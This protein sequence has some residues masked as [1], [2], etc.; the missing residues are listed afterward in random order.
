MCFFVYGGPSASFRFLFSDT[1]ALMTLF[2]VLGL[3]LLFVRVTRLRPEPANL[4]PE[5]VAHE[6]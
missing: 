2:D 1:P 6:G 5:N 4:F 3:A